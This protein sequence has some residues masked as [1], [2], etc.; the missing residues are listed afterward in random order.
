M[1]PGMCHLDLAVDAASHVLGRRIRPSRI[2]RARF[3]RKV[4]PGEDLTILIRIEEPAGSPALVRASHSVGMEP[5]AEILFE[6]EP[7]RTTSPGKGG[8]PA[9]C[10]GDPRHHPGSSGP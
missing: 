5:A 2:L 4:V 3:T 1:L 9:A 8:P 10:A 6:I 7:E